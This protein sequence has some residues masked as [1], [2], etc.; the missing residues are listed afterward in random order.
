MD[1]VAPIA[2]ILG[3]F[4]GNW[5]AVARYRRELS[6]GRL[7]RIH[8]LGIQL[9]NLIADIV[10]SARG[11]VLPTVK[12]QP[13]SEHLSQHL[14]LLRNLPTEQLELLVR[15]HAPHAFTS[16]N[17]LDRIVDELTD[18]ACPIDWNDK[19]PSEREKIFW[20]LSRAHDRFLEAYGEFRYKIEEEILR[21]T[22]GLRYAAI[23]KGRHFLLAAYNRLRW[24]R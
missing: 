19:A 9:R 1:W 20:E 7:E 15:I 18:M 10:G 23:N 11:A 6:I 21:K 2:G 16:F 22:K 13:E 12:L 24:W 5:Q 4:I 17:K 8:N 14:D 3:V